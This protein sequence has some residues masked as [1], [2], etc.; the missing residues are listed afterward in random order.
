VTCFTIVFMSIGGLQIAQQF[1]LSIGLSRW[2]LFSIMIFIIFVLGMFMHWP[3][4]V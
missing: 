4:I 3:P 2:I 1:M